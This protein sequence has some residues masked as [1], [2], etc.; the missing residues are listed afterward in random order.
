[1][2]GRIPGL[3]ARSIEAVAVDGASEQKRRAAEPRLAVGRGDRGKHGAG[4][5]PS[6]RVVLFCFAFRVV[7]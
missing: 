7:F 5:T 4:K 2:P 6:V 1:M 3:G